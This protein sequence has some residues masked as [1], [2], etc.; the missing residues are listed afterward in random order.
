MSRLQC[1][2]CDMALSDT[3]SPS[4]H[5]GL[6]VTDAARD[7]VTNYSGANERDVIDADELEERSREVWECW[8]CGSLMVED[9]PGSGT[10]TGYKKQP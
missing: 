1:G 9:A 8:Q 7:G 2:T 6:F 4:K 3:A 5:V 10:F